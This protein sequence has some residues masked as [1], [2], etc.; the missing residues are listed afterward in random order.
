MTV[1]FQMR[2]KTARVVGIRVSVWRMGIL[3][4]KSMLLVLHD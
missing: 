1:S 3:G 2:A 4:R